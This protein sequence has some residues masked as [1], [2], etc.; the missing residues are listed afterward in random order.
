MANNCVH[1]SNSHLII[2]YCPRSCEALLTRIIGMCDY[3]CFWLHEFCDVL[4]RADGE[5]CLEDC[6]ENATQLDG[7][8]GRYINSG[9]LADYYESI[10]QTFRGWVVWARRTRMSWATAWHFSSSLNLLHYFFEVAFVMIMKIHRFL[11]A[12]YPEILGIY[13]SYMNTLL[14]FC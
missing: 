4:L 3:L 6:S 7:S 9:S 8:E 12:L 1:K 5:W 14:I 11:F 2:R 10:R 13:L